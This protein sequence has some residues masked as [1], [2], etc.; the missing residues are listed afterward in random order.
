[1]L[2]GRSAGLLCICAAALAVGCSR[3]SEESGVTVLRPGDHDGH[4]PV[5]QRR[6]YYGKP[7]WGIRG[8]NRQEGG[9]IW[10]NHFPGETGWYCVSAGVILENDGRGRFVLKAGDR[11]LVDMRFPFAHGEQK[12]CDRRGRTDRLELGRFHLQ[13]GQKISVYGTSDY[14]CGLEHGGAYTLWHALEFRAV[15][16]DSG[17]PAA[18]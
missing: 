8:S 6:A 11:P 15:P 17:C 2:I 13:K 5:W 18:R 3:A 12:D 10:F 4:D 14:A 1:M 16:A 9:W 7:T